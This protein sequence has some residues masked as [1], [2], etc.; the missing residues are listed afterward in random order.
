MPGDVF[1]QEETPRNMD[2]RLPLPSDVDNFVLLQSATEQ[3]EHEQDPHEK[4]KYRKVV[5]MI[6]RSI[7]EKRQHDLRSAQSGEKASS[8]KQ[9]YRSATGESDVFEESEAKVQGQ[10]SFPEA[11][12]LLRGYTEED[13]EDAKKTLAKETDLEEK[14]KWQAVVEI[15]ERVLK[16]QRDT[17]EHAKRERLEALQETYR[18]NNERMTEKEQN[19]FLEAIVAL[20]EE[21][22]VERE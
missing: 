1:P 19:S 15:I 8:A 14:E 2:E 11:S 17:S 3:Y 7:E 12:D 9:H 18:Q 10:E 4:E 6:E 21:L 13:L 22:G 5:A 20:E 16:S